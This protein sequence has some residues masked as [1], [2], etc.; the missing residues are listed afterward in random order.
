MVGALVL[1]AVVAKEL[2]RQ[3]GNTL[4][5]NTPVPDAPARQVADAAPALA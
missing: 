2:N 1:E 5:T 4:P 3:A